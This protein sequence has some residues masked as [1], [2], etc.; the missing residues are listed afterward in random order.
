MSAAAE[1]TALTTPRLTKYIPHTPTDRQ[2]AGLLLPNREVL[3]GGA[4][5]PGKTDWLLM[6][7]LQYV[8]IPG[9]SALLLRRTFK[10]L[11]K[12]GSLLPRSHDWLRNTDASW[13]GEKSQWT[14]P[15][16]ATLE[17]GHMQHE[18]NKYDYQSAEY[19]FVG[20]DELTQFYESMYRYLHSRTR[21]LI[22]VQIPIRVWSASNPGGVGHDWVK[23]RLVIPGLKAGALSNP[24]QRVFLP[25]KL[26]DNP[27]LDAQEY[28]S[29]LNELDPVTRQQLLDGDWDAKPG[30][31]I[32]RKQDFELVDAAP[33]ECIRGRGWDFAATMP[34]PGKDPDWTIGARIALCLNTRLLYIEHVERYRLE[35]SDTED[36]MVS[37]VQLDGVAVRQRLEQEGG[38]SGKLFVAAVTKRLIGYDVEGIPVSGDKSL[39]ARALAS[40]ARAGNVKLVRGMWNGPF[41]DVLD[42]FGPDC[43]HDDDVDATSVIF[44][45]MCI[46][47]EVSFDDLY[48]EQSNTSSG[49]ETESDDF[50][51]DEEFE[52]DEDI[53]WI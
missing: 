38:S 47:I 10:Q 7:A 46:D 49:V 3:Y 26:K 5:G 48:G 18:D 16:G 30:G 41:M 27:Y 44:N 37:V 42:S 51:Y 2:A 12:A 32:F 24:R 31:V 22:G 13:N 53:A 34:K 50:D 29:S 20:F 35:P 39:R 23:E 9:Y 19:Q 1:L 40:Y 4:A 43:A 11:S 52:G 45:D 28:E 36:R 17:F 25:G 15:S 14:F 21:R 6:A 8:D 33:I